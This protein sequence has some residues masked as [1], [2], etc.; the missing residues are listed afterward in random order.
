[1]TYEISEPVCKYADVTDV[2]EA[3]Q[4]LEDQDNLRIWKYGEYRAF[5]LLIS[6]NIE[7]DID[8]GK[9]TTIDILTSQYVN[10]RIID[11]DEVKGVDP[12][13]L[14]YQLERLWNRRD[15]IMR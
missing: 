5:T 13:E 11:V 2:I 8:C 15:L 3:V 9:I 1:M 14:D 4:G 10:G 12:E 6:K 7:K